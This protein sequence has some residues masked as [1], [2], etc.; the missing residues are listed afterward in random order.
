MFHLPTYARIL[1]RKIRRPKN[2]LAQVIEA[3]PNV[4]AVCILLSYIQGVGKAANRSLSDLTSEY[5]EGAPR[6]IPSTDTGDLPDNAAGD[7][8]LLDR[9]C[10]LGYH[11]GSLTE[12][13]HGAQDWLCT[14]SLCPCCL[15]NP[16]MSQTHLVREQ[17]MSGPRQR[18]WFL[19]FPLSPISCSAP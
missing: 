16:A 10:T 2:A 19:L 14:L 17:Q 3:V 8:S 4:S 1:Q 7:T 15:S 12:R 11:F 5:P 18:L 6:L 9:D 13:D